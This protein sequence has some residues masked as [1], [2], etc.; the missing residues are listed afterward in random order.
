MVP[1]GSFTFVCSTSPVSS[2]DWLSGGRL[3]VTLEGLTFVRSKSAAETLGTKRLY[4]VEWPEID[5]VELLVPALGKPILWVVVSG[6]DDSEDAPD[7][8]YAYRVKRRYVDHVRSLVAEINQESE[9]RRRWTRPE[10]P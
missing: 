10:A 6:A 7:G 5:R 9:V 4:E 2:E 1:P 8:R 3:E